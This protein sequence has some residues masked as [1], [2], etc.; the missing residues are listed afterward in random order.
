M[1]LHKSRREGQ[2]VNI[3]REPLH[4]EVEI[5]DTWIGGTQ[6][7]FPGGVGFGRSEERRTASR[8]AR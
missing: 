1:L 2:C 6:V 3:A 8:Q 5:D 4:G 7:S